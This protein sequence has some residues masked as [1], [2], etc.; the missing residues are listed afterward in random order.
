MELRGGDRRMRWLD[1][2]R[3]RFTWL[4]EHLQGEDWSVAWRIDYRRA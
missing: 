1:V 2:E 3:D 4:W